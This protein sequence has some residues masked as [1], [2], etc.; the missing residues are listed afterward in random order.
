MEPWHSATMFGYW[1]LDLLFERL[2]N[3]SLQIHSDRVTIII[4]KLCGLA[5]I[6][7][8]PKL[9]EL[10]SKDQDGLLDRIKT[11]NLPDGDKEILTGLIEF[12]NWL[13]FSSKR[14]V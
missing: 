13:Q 10:S 1:L 9:V 8:Q 7:K 5:I 3:R 4:L 2:S 6:M 14:K 12:D 11:A